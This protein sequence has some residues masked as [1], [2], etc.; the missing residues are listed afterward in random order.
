MWWWCWR[1]RR[2][3]IVIE[4]AQ[5][6]CQISPKFAHFIELFAQGRTGEAKHKHRRASPT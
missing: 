6:A 4:H 5:G 3:F 1:R 2:S